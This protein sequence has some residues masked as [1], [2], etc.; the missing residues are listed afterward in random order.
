[1]FPPDPET[2]GPGIPPPG[3]VC[4][5]CGRQAWDEEGRME[6]GQWLCGPCV[7][8]LIARPVADDKF[9]LNPI[10]TN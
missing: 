6:K 3:F 8:A 2:E 4:H 10:L 9:P 7:R 5:A 1:M